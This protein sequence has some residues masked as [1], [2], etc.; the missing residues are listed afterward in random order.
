[1]FTVVKDELFLE[2]VVEGFLFVVWID[3]T[4]LFCDFVLCSDYFYLP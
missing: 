4:L 2:F 1:M 3:L